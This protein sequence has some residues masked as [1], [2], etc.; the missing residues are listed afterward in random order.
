[1]TAGPRAFRPALRPAFRPAFWPAVCAAAMVAG[2]ADA[3]VRYR[4]ELL[5]GSERVALED[6]SARFSAAVRRCTAFEVAD[7]PGPRIETEFTTLAF[8]RPRP[9]PAPLTWRTNPQPLALGAPH[10]Q[11]MVQQ[12]S[13]K[14]GLDPRLVGAL[15][16]VESAYQTQARSPKGALGLMQIMPATGARYGVA[17]RQD[18]LDPATNID[19]GARYLRDLNEMFDGRVDLVLAAY[20]AG[21]GAVKRYG[22]RI[23]PY[24]ETQDYVRKILKLYEG[25]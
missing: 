18:L 17:S 21:E 7:L 10:L 24:R 15:V 2:P 4:C 25:E 8:T 5:D 23:P 13:R 22:N 19:V 16:H 14:H 11:R 6:L 1:M 3:G 12:A 9:S 20:N